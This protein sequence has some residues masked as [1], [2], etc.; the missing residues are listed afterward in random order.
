MLGADFSRDSVATRA[1]LGLGRGQGLTWCRANV[2]G[3]WDLQGHESILAKSYLR[4]W[5]AWV[6]HV[7][8]FPPSPFEHAGKM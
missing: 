2:G 7:K 5:L 1:L 6:L 8:L 4:P 3:Q